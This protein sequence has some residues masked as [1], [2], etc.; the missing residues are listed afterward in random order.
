MRPKWNS[1]DAAL[2]SAVIE[3]YP[4]STARDTEAPGT[5][6][7]VYER[8]RLQR[9]GFLR[10]F[11]FTDIPF[12]VTPDPDFLFPSA[13]HAAA[14][15]ALVASIES[16]LGFSV[17]IGEPGTGKTTL[18]FQLLTQYRDGARTAF[19]FQTQCRP[20]ELLRHIAHELEVPVLPHDEVKLH[21]RLKAMLVREARAGRKVIIVVDE[22]QNLESS[23]LEAIRLLSDFETAPAKLLHVILSGS[24][25]LAETLLSP[26]LSPLAQRI[27][28]V[29]RLEPLNTNELRAY[30]SFRVQKAGSRMTDGFFSKNSFYEI[31]QRTRGVPRLVNS[32]CYRA[33]MLAYNRGEKCVNKALI[34]QAASDLDLSGSTA[35]ELQVIGDSTKGANTYPATNPPFYEWRPATTSVSEVEPVNS[36]GHTIS[37][38]PP[39]HENREDQKAS[40][41]PPL[42]PYFTDGFKNTVGPGKGRVSGSP[43]RRLT[44]AMSH[45]DRST[46]LLAGMVLLALAFWTGWYVLGISP[47]RSVKPTLHQSHVTFPTTQGDTSKHATYQQLN[48]SNLRSLEDQ[49]LITLDE[50][51]RT[52][53]EATNRRLAAGTNTHRPAAVVELSSDHVV[54]STLQ[55]QP[56]HESDSAIPSNAETISGSN[57]TITL[58]IASTGS[59]IPRLESPVSNIGSGV[60][61]AV[62]LHPV[63]VV[64]PV[65]P[66]KA[67]QWRIEGDVLLQLTIDKSGAVKS[68]RPLSGNA[69]LTQA[70]E[71]A[72]LQW[73]YQLSTA[74]QPFTPVVT[75]ARFNFR[76]TPPDKK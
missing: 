1:F 43:L 53:S 18:L 19:I 33:L 26:E 73:R 11:G 28:T 10:Y 20:R 72:A 24:F 62:P 3:M 69:I 36:S 14:L 58:P 45:Y 49:P 23:S 68:V 9:E 32:L 29:C 7:P 40:F 55:R 52:G 41:V 37:E 39:R 76:L 5:G 70:A 4:P 42:A 57:A 31:S 75:Q 30:V 60:L 17:L 6:E 47:A 35:P 48:E 46:Q 16:N 8:A 66:E 61:H 65:Y 56:P 27:S 22:A 2:M 34:Q 74:N 25:R 12:G 54:P 38:T 15:E 67:K 51:S 13:M 21:Q 71:K 63:K 44:Q 50:S 64:Q 59:A